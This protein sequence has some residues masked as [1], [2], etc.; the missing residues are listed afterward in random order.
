R[1]TFNE[2]LLNNPIFLCLKVT[3][4]IN[5]SWVSV[6]DKHHMVT[7][8]YAFFDGYAFA[9]EA[10]ARDFA[11]HSYP[12]SLLYLDERSNLRPA[13]NLAAVKIDELVD[14]YVFAERYIVGYALAETALLSGF[15]MR[16]LSRSF[17]MDRSAASSSSTTRSPA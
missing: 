8:K 12:C 7:H 9:D 5:S 10:V 14:L 4:R 15:H 6:V 1:S 16:G 17:F 11:V 3:R 13:S 2:G